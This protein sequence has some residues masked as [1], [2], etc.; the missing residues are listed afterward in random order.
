MTS[1]PFAKTGFFFSKNFFEIWKENLGSTLKPVLQFPDGI[2]NN[3]Q[4]KFH[5]RRSFA[6]VENAQPLSL[7][8]FYRRL[9]CLAVRLP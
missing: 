7:V 4:R 1:S 3:C 2:Q 6:V 9:A 8:Y 5:W